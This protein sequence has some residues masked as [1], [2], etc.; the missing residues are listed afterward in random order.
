MYFNGY[1]KVSHTY[2][3]CKAERNPSDADANAARTASIAPHSRRAISPHDVPTIFCPIAQARR[4]ARRRRQTV[5]TTAGGGGVGFLMAHYS[6][7]SWHTYRINARL[8]VHCKVCTSSAVIRIY[9]DSRAVRAWVSTAPRMRFGAHYDVR[10]AS[11]LA[12]PSSS[13]PWLS[14]SPHGAH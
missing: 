1:F 6:T 10:P 11:S 7:T 5:P 3:H 4:R 2:R 13:A 12:A 9:S 14:S 8:R